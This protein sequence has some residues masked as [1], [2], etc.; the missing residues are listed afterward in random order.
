MVMAGGQL[1]TAASELNLYNYH[2]GGGTSNHASRLKGRLSGFSLH[3]LDGS[4]MLVF[5][6][7]FPYVGLS[8]LLQDPIIV[9][10]KQ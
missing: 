9:Y 7:R 3:F 8:N 5:R 6:S 1:V 4:F 10:N 2:I